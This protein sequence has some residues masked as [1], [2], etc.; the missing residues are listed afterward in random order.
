[1]V[2]GELEVKVMVCELHEVECVVVVSA[3]LGV[4]CAVSGVLRTITYYHGSYKGID[5]LMPTQL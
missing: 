1:M 3:V 5:P 2:C 4:E